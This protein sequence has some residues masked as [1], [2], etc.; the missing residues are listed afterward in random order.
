MEG[1]EDFDEMK[2]C[3]YRLYID[4]QNLS[5]SLQREMDLRQN[6]IN[7]FYNNFQSLVQGDK[8]LNNNLSSMVTS[9]L[10]RSQRLL[11][12]LTKK[13]EECLQY[14]AKLRI[15]N[16]SIEENEA[17]IN[18]L[19]AQ[20]NNTTFIPYEIQN[21]NDQLIRLQNELDIANE[22]IKNLKLQLDEHKSKN[23]QLQDELTC[24][25][26]IITNKESE[27]IELKAAI[28]HLTNDLKQTH[29]LL[30]DNQNTIKSFFKTNEDSPWGH[31]KPLKD[32]IEELTNELISANKISELEKKQIERQTSLVP[33]SNVPIDY[34]KLNSQLLSIKN[35]MMRTYDDRF[36][37]FQNNFE[38]ILDELHDMQNAVNEPPPPLP[39]EPQ[40]NFYSFNKILKGILYCSLL[41]LVLSNI[42]P[43]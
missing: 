34:A 40:K 21:N 37:N 11:E 41:I 14:K 24:K 16:N 10:N 1:D 27:C 25:N 43:H 9:N 29:Q 33:V 39:Q 30:V 26:S 20:L 31:T 12:K 28:T 13:S 3:Y 22:T 4:Y 5:N 23:L 6:M 42:K 15:A 19:K 35:E 32:K 8:A 36:S 38:M 18:Y 17:E 7:T 2:S